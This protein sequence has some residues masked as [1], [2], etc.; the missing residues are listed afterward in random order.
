MYVEPFNNI[1]RKQGLRSRETLVCSRGKRERPESLCGSLSGTEF[2]LAF[3]D[4][5]EPKNLIRFCMANFYVLKV[6]SIFVAWFYS[7]YRRM[8]RW[9]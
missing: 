8:V 6:F 5:T 7:H 3:Q 1:R 4:R 2:R 9:R